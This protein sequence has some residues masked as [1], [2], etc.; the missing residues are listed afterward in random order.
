MRTIR[1][2]RRTY[3]VE[4]VAV[5]DVDL[6]PA[7]F[8]LH[9]PRGRKYLLVPDAGRP[10][11]LVAVAPITPFAPYRPRPFPGTWFTVTDEG[12]LVIAPPDL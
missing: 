9:D 10:D 7:R 1:F 6:A 3:L 8:I 12:R 11:R 4:P 2:G 5:S